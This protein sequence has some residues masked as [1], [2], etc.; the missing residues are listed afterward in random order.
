VLIVSFL[1]GTARH[2]LDRC[3]G[4]IAERIMPGQRLLEWHQVRIDWPSTYRQGARVARICQ[5]ATH[6]HPARL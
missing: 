3:A 5:H 1:I 2:S 6:D 4:S